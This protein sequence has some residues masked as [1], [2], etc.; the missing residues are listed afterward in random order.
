MVK[1]VIELL[2]TV[3]GRLDDNIDLENLEALRDFYE[4]FVITLAKLPLITL[5]VAN[6]P[7]AKRFAIAVETYGWHP[8]FFAM[9]FRGEEWAMLV[10]HASESGKTALHW[11]A[12]QYG[13]S[14]SYAGLVVELIRQG[15]DVHACW[16]KPPL[17]HVQS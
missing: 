7:F 8:D 12:E 4:R 3:S 9:A 17:F 2:A 1:E 11:A 15:S 5:P 16:N 13:W 6:I 14:E 10:T